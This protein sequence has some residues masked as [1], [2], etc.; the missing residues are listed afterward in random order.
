LISD[1]RKER[2]AARRG[3]E[4]VDGKVDLRQKYPGPAPVQY[5]DKMK[6]LAR[7]CLIG[8]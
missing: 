3:S 7:Q 2:V 8:I 6:K 4:I 1:Q 5:R